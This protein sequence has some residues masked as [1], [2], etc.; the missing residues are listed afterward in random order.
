MRSRSRLSALVVVLV[1]TAGC[2]DAPSPAEGA[3][4]DEAIGS[5]SGSS[6]DEAGSSE[7]ASGSTGE[8]EAPD[9]C[10][11][12]CADLDD[13]AGVATCHACRCKDAFDDWLP[14]VDELQCA[15]GVP[16][17]T[18]HAELTDT[19]YALEPS[20]PGATRCANPSLLTGSCQQGSKLGQLTHGDVSVYWICRDPYLDYDGSILYGDMAVIGHNMRSGATC[21]WDDI[22][23]VI[24]EDDAPP[25]DLLEASEEERVRSVELF[26]YND[27]S[28]CVTCH[29][30]DPFIYTPYL[31]STGWRSI[32][33][34]KGP[35][36]L[37][38][39]ERTPR[40][41]G[42]MHLVSPQAS[43][44][45]SCHRLGSDNTCSYFAPNSLARLQTNAHE[46]Q[47]HEAA[48]PGSPAWRLAHWM[49]GPVEDIATLSD[50]EATYGDARDH[51]LE[52]CG[53]PGV[54]TGDCQWAPVPVE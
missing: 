21:F 52:C 4:D 16:I 30:H 9:A 34:D 3:L 50:W 6:G 19:D 45:T 24:H 28:T 33:A 10:A 38:T 44:C 49:P 35:Y 37:V 48:E 14:S 7:Q 15:H 41:T 51:V 40:P 29:D 5:G 43:A 17:V 27:G 23:D 53:S 2:P 42:I 25:L 26:Q 32:A 54:D 12:A 8:P 13:R 39:L 11:S 36:H 46:A 1:G 47:I 20:P 18:L 22:D 31:Q